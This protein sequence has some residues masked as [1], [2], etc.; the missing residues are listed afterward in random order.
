MSYDQHTICKSCLGSE[1]AYAALSQQVACT[2]C[3]R[4]PS[5]DRKRRADALAAAA[6]ED[7]WPVQAFEPVDCSLISLEPSA[8]QELDD[9]YPASLHSSPCGSPLPPLPRTGETESEQGAGL[10]AEHAVPFSVTTA[11]PAIG[12]I[13]GELPEIICKAAPSSGQVCS[14][15]HGR[16][17]FRGC[18]RSGVIR[19]GHAFPPSGGTRR[20]RRRTRG[21][22]I[23][24][25]HC[26]YH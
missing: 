26:S 3:A 4:L 11:L 2:H 1:H 24:A 12:V 22:Y 14:G 19:S 15:R 21:P 6:E 8:G 5:D 16:S 18:R 7:D 17:F 13:L 10:A 9:S 23:M 25:A 20:G